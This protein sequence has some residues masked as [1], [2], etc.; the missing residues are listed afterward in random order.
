MSESKTTK[1]EGG[2]VIEHGSSPTYKPRY[3]CGVHEFDED[4]LKAVR[5]SREI[6]AQSEAEYLDNDFDAANIGNYRVAYHEWG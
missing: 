6:D 3:W 1:V 5:L 4:H 2:W